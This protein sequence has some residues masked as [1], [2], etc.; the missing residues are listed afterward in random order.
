MHRPDGRIYEGQWMNAKK[1]GE[2]IYTDRT[3]KARREV[4]VNGKLTQ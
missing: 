2:G 3:G 1:H 4:W